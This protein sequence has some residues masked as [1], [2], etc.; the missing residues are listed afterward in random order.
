MRSFFSWSIRTHLLLLVLAA[1]IP[2]LALVWW[3]GQELERQA[4]HRA[5]ETTMQLAA[6]MAD[7]LEQVEEHARVLLTTL[8]QV[9]SIRQMDK[10]AA[11][12][13][14]TQLNRQNPAYA[15]IFLATPAG[16][17]LALSFPFPEMIDITSRKYYK[18][19]LRTRAFSVGEYAVSL[20]TKRP[21]IHFALPVLGEGGELIGIVAAGYDLGTLAQNFSSAGLPEGSS[22][23][24]SDS[25]GVRLFRYPD[26][27]RWVGQMEPRDMWLG[28]LN[29]GEEGLTLAEG[30]DGVRRLYAV[31][32]LR[33]HKDD[34]AFLL[35]RVGIP[36]AKALAETRR[37]Q[38]RNVALMLG[39]TMLA[40]A[41]AFMLGNLLI[42]RRVERL[43]T[44]AQRL[45]DG[46]LSARSGLGHDEGELGKLAESFDDM[47][48][49]LATRETERLESEAKLRHQALYDP[50]TGLANRTLALDRVQ[51]ALER[52]KRRD[53]VFYAVVTLDLDRFKVINDSLGHAVGDQVLETVARRIVGTL[54]GLDTVARFGGNEFI[55]LLEEL[56]TPGEA[57][58]IVKRLRQVVMEPVPVAG[59]EVQTSAS[60]GIVLSPNAFERA[61]DLLQSAAI[62]LH[63]VKQ[64]G[65]GRF[66]V[67][68]PRML[69]HAVERLTLEQELRQGLEQNQFVVYYQP[70]WAL[71]STRLVGFEALVRWAHP[72][73]GMVGPGSF[74]ALAEE[75]GIILELGRLV[76]SRACADLAQWRERDPAARKL[77]VAVNLSNKQFSQHT[78]VEQ[79]SEILRSTRLPADRLK[80][81]ITES[82]IMVNAESALVMLKRLKALGVAISIDD[83]GT[84]YSSLSYLQRFPVDTLK[85]DRS[86]VGRLGLDPE[87]QEIVRAIV[88]LAHSLGLEVVAEGVE[89]SGQAAM[90]KALGCECVQGFY[91]SR[92]LDGDRAQETIGTSMEGR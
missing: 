3:S 57:I 89:E 67:F 5:Q 25:K 30:A 75:T 13:L 4:V 31:K 73:R 50:L 8:A 14:L 71:S 36:E 68:T 88:A 81:E 59:R 45:R 47:A 32:R 19:V 83:F 77:F 2:A 37:I 24:L 18:D 6:G 78:L 87:N 53:D 82:N 92:P 22:M 40:A 52:C 60:F 44:A 23:A 62:A 80:L 28:L 21:V 38:S 35:L 85:V 46:D 1:A 7:E 64:S 12:A 41:L 20:T 56:A 43:T 58:R 34:T 65:R 61:E 79:V 69:M 49:A 86:F 9:P 15:S 26:S 54:R 66:K 90:L 11:T 42:M 33:A 39:A 63:A 91:F 29:L 17:I 16:K 84:G 27:E 55:L 51:Q 70:I 74:I 76:L 48:L 72:E 10:R